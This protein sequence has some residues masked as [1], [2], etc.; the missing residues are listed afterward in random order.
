MMS[1]IISISCEQTQGTR[2][3]PP[4]NF[5]NKFK[6]MD[7]VEETPLA[8]KHEYRSFIGL[9]CNAAAAA[10]VDSLTPGIPIAVSAVAS[11]HSMAATSS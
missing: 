2:Q 8:I 11:I 1:F 5:F 7:Q 9:L 3:R 4:T 6:L 10:A